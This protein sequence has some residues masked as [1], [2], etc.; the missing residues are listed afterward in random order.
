MKVEILKVSGIN[1]ALF[2]MRNPLNSWGLSDTKDDII[3]EKDLKLA[4]RLI[5]RKSVV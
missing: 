5:D 3:G 4:Q 1:E 2:G